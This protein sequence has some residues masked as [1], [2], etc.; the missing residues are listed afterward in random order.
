MAKPKRQP[1]KKYNDDVKEKVRALLAINN[2]ISQV[3]KQTG[4]AYSTIHDWKRAFEQEEGEN[5]LDILRENKKKEF[6]DSTW[7]TIKMTESLIHRRIK[8]A[9]DKESEIDEVIKAVAKAD[10]Y[11]A[12][13]KE[14]INQLKQIK[15]EDISKLSTVFGVL[16]DKHALANK[17][18]TSIVDG[19]IKVKKFE[20]Y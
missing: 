8:R 6:I 15:I 5:N 7:E 13:K 16:Y 17:E 20:D 3:A 10:L 1:G 19:N 14:I 2:S 12:E 9:V 4:L 11:P 18:A